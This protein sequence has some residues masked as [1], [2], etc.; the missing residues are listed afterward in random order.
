MYVVDDLTDRVGFGGNMKMDS[1]RHQPH[2]HLQS[3]FDMYPYIVH[4]LLRHSTN[5]PGRL[6]KTRSLLL[7]IFL[8]I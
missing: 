4:I 5:F 3:A 8:D 1:A 7:L 2:F 6:G